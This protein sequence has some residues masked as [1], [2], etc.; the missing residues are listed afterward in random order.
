MERAM[1]R[2]NNET[3]QL[4]FAFKDAVLLVPIGASTIAIIWDIGSFL[5]VGG[6]H[7]FTLSEHI[8]SALRALPIALFVSIGILL[9]FAAPFD[10]VSILAKLYQVL[11]ESWFYLPL[12]L[13]TSGVALLGLVIFQLLTPLAV[14]VSIG[15]VGL[16][17]GRKLATIRSAGGLATF[18]CLIMFL[19]FIM[20][21]DEMTLYLNGPVT[22]SA[23]LTTKT[24]TVVGKII[25]SGERGVLLFKDETQTIIFTKADEIK[26]IEWTR[27]NNRI[28]PLWPS[29]RRFFSNL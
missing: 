3:K 7:Y 22:D 24:E 9:I 5:V 2:H 1:T 17:F 23:K 14:L 11:F 13:L 26:S 18:A 15:I 28:I 29:V 4:D 20:A 16:T 10:K 19:T 21:S 6:F 27:R 25:M 12:L 8:L